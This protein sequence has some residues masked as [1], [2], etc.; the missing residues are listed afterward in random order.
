METSRAKA[1]EK[2]VVVMEMQMWRRVKAIGVHL[3]GGVMDPLLSASLSPS[4]TA[5][6]PA[7]LQAWLD[8]SLLQMDPPARPYLVPSFLWVPV[9][10]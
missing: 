10:H 9:F 1:S 4:A 2:D 5:P 6:C 8:L 7:M 3:V